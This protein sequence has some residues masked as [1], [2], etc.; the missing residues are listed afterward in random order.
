[1]WHSDQFAEYLHKMGT[2]GG[3]EAFLSRLQEQGTTD[4]MA[5]ESSRLGAMCSLALFLTRAHASTPLDEVR[6]QAESRVS[7]LCSSCSDEL[8]MGLGMITV[9]GITA[10]LSVLTTRGAIID[11]VKEQLRT[12]EEALTSDGEAVSL[13]RELGPALESDLERSGVS[14]EDACAV[15]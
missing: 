13:S 8:G 9:V 11:G 3:P 14:A 10:K 12:L 2:T 6:K 15:M 7:K 4:S 5:D 1:M